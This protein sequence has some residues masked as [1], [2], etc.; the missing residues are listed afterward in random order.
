M[1]ILIDTKNPFVPEPELEIDQLVLF[2]ENETDCELLQKLF[3]QFEISGCG[4]GVFEKH[5]NKPVHVSIKL[6]RKQNEP[7]EE[8][9]PI[10]WTGSL[11]RLAME[12]GFPV[13]FSS[14]DDTKPATGG[15]TPEA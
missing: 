8:P 5:K 6:E 15:G 4:F 1:K 11:L 3:D 7:D 9:K 10:E 14:D 13:S 2:A 12:S